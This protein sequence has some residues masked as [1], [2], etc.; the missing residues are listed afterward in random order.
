VDG[1]FNVINVFG[2]SISTGYCERLWRH[3]LGLRLNF[4][5]IELDGEVSLRGP[6]I[7]S[8][9]KPRGMGVSLGLRLGF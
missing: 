6:D 7:V 3:A 8:S 4:R 5:A 9:F 1:E 2:L